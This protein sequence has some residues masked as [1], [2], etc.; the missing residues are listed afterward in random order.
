MRTSAAALALT[1]A[2]IVPTVAMAKQPARTVEHLKIVGDSTN[3]SW[4]YTQGNIITFVNV[5]VTNDNVKDDTGK[6]KDAIVSLAIS[7]AEVDTGNVLIAGVAYTNDFH[8]W[9]DKDLG[10]AT[11]TVT[12]AIFQD[13]NSFTFFN[14]NMNLTWTA[15][16]AMTTQKTKDTFVAP[17]LRMKTRFEGDFRDAVASGSIFG[18]G[19]QF[20]P[21]PSSMGQLQHNNF[22]SLTITV[23]P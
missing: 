21:M 4:S 11:L 10:S 17:G 22:G 1:L 2:T 16:A 18:K 23:E 5:V 19:I 13:D 12:D 15:T 8:L 20:I 6:S 7:Q 14:V 9:V 3:A